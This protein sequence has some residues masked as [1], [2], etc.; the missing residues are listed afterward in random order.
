V[1]YVRILSSS[2]G[3]N[4]RKTARMPANIGIACQNTHACLN[5]TSVVPLFCHRLGIT[6]AVENKGYKSTGEAG[7]DIVNHVMLNI[8]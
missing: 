1:A 8:R 5:A 7:D 4:Q 6:W 3:L 2:G